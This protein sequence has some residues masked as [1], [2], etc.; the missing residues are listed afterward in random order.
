MSSNSTQIVFANGSFIPADEARV[1]VFDRGFLYGDGLFE[2]MPVRSGRPIFW[3]VHLHRMQRGA[4]YLRIKIPFDPQTLLTHARQLIRENRVVDGTLRLN[5]SRGVGPRGYSP[6]GANQPTLV[7]S[8][9]AADSA[10]PAAREWKLV[11]A[12]FRVLTDDPLSIYKTSNKLPQIAARAFA[13]DHKADE[14]LLL[15]S[16]GNLA[17]T[18]AANVFC[19]LN[20]VVHTPPIGSGALAGVTRQAVL[21]IC[22]TEGIPSCERVITPEDARRSD[23]LFLT[24]STIGIVE[25]TSLD[26]L[27]LSRSP[28]T[29]KLRELYDQVV[30]PRR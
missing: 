10:S 22:R 7:M 1:S 6:A 2:T 5:L 11:T 19:V 29:H 23:G 14:A 20:R 15:N 28:L 12:P 8:T 17:E 4:N 13:E 26:G 21:E 16:D 3:E 27:Q 25:A 9:H 24:L 18:S 30:M